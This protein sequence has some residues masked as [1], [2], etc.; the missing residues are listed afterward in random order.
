MS[1]V[2]ILSVL[3]LSLLLLWLGKAGS[4]LSNCFL[5]VSENYKEYPTA[6]EQQEISREEFESIFIDLREENENC[7]NETAKL[8][9][10]PDFL[11]DLLTTIF[12][13]GKGLP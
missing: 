7:Q 4:N 12:T 11:I 10:L 6:Y 5:E 8:Y 3:I 2:I 9:Y 1:K 13:K